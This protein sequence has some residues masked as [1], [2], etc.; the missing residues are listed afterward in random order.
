MTKK[1]EKPQLPHPEQEGHL[2][3]S[4]RLAATS[5]AGLR[6]LLALTKASTLTSTLQISIEYYLRNLTNI[7][8]SL[9]QQEVDR[10]FER[11]LRLVK[12][13]IAKQTQ[14]SKKKRKRS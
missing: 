10:E 2:L 13:T 12:A 8:G 7:Y 4:F 11:Q 5:V 3:C 1:K 14:K 6:T 9:T